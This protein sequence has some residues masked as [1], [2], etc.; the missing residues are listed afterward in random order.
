MHKYF[1]KAYKF[2]P[3]PE[4]K[5]HKFNP[6]LMG[7]IHKENVVNEEHVAEA[8]KDS[9][10]QID[11]E[12]QLSKFVSVIQEAYKTRQKKLV[13]I[14]G[15][16]GSGKSLFLR[17]GFYEFL[18]NNKDFYE[19][20]FKTETKRIF[21]CTYQTPITQK[22]PFNGFYKIFR[23]MFQ[24]LFLYFD[25]K[26][27]IKSFKFAKQ[28]SNGNAESL[29]DQGSVNSKIKRFDEEIIS[30][31]IQEKCFYLI[32]Y[33]ELILKKDLIGM[34]EKRFKKAPSKKE[35]SDPTNNNF[36]KNNVN[37]GANQNKNHEENQDADNLNYAQE[38]L[39][40]FNRSNFIYFRIK[41]LLKKLKNQIH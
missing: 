37:Q 19:S 8:L 24:Y 26:V 30:I 23:E 41:L 9:L 32:K 18:N 25:E 21:F 22:K 12:A 36:D 38:N 16:T 7:Q 4:I 39:Y 28:S 1:L 10:F 2:N 34:F 27:N 31:I 14:K 11:R 29:K 17:R 15:P 6:I 33:L 20:V 3:F 40:T 5:T 13:L 35:D